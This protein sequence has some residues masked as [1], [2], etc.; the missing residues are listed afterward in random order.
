MCLCHDLTM[1]QTGSGVPMLNGMSQDELVLV[2]MA[3]RAGLVEFLDRDSSQLRIKV[4]GKIEVYKNLKFFDF[5]SD[6]KMM[7]RIVQNV[8]TEEVTVLAKGAD[9]SI[10]KRCLPVA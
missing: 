6:R 8:E 2:D 10:F 1:V 5:T 9:S 4:K 3:K 7:T